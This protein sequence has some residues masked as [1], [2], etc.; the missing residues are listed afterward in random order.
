MDDDITGG[1]R[2]TWRSGLCF[3]LGGQRKDHQPPNHFKYIFNYKI[4]L[5][6][7]YAVDQ[8]ILACVHSIVFDQGLLTMCSA[9]SYPTGRGNPDACLIPPSILGLLASG[10]RFF[11]TADLYRENRHMLVLG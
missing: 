6:Q 5:I 7:E 2:D 9:T 11:L 4:L 8:R 3:T 1:A 10:I